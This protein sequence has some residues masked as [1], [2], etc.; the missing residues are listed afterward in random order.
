MNR[1]GTDTRDA[2]LSV[3]VPLALKQAIERYADE[4]R[5]TVADV[6]ILLLEEIVEIERVRRMTDEEAQ[7]ELKR[8]ARPWF[9]RSLRQRKAAR[10]A[11]GKGSK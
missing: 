8:L 7:R 4:D 9:P 2:R 5:R 6:V 10:R 11:A 3:R 1:K